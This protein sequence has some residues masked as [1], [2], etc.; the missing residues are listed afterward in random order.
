MI[1]PGRHAVA[2]SSVSANSRRRLSITIGEKL[3]MA[4]L[5]GPVVMVHRPL[6]WNPLVGAGARIPE[7]SPARRFRNPSTRP[8]AL[9]TA[10]AAGN[11][12]EMNSRPRAH[13]VH[14]ALL[15]GRERKFQRDV[16]HCSTPFASSSANAA[17]ASRGR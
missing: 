17:A 3:E 6:G 9:K 1:G 2:F 16:A 15:T 10:R 5:P 7:K 12:S 4:H 14:N 8:A 13:G 11:S